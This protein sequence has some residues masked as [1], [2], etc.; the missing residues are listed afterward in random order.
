MRVPRNAAPAAAAVI[1]YINV[2]AVAKDGVSKRKLAWTQVAEGDA[3]EPLL[4]KLAGTFVSEDGRTIEV[5]V[6]L[7]KEDTGFDF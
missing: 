5:V 2:L 3:L 4:E 6:N 1:G 7:V